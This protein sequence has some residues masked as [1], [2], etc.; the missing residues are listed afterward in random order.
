M[1]RNGF[2]ASEGEHRKKRD[3]R[4]QGYG[5][6]VTELKRKVEISHQVPFSPMPCL[7]PGL[8]PATP[9]QSPP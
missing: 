7:H 5:D 6:K 3:H 2:Q 4:P 8:V 9:G 1:H